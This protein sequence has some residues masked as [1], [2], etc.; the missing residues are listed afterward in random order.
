M[1]R[2]LETEIERSRRNVN[3]SLYLLCSSLIYLISS[4]YW[5]TS[6]T[7]QSQHVQI[8]LLNPNRSSYA[9]STPHCSHISHFNGFSVLCIKIF[10]KHLIV[11]HI[12]AAKSLSPFFNCWRFRL[13]PIL[14]CFNEHSC[15]YICY[16][17]LRIYSLAQC[18][19]NKFLTIIQ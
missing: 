16:Y 14:W 9:D 1:T 5:G 3:S 8:K 2:M 10:W 6:Y 7:S 19:K 12:E 13:F 15:L 17:C 11:Y 4:L 18:N